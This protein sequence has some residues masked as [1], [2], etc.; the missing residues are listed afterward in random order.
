MERIFPWPPSTTDHQKCFVLLSHVV[1][2]WNGLSQQSSSSSREKGKTD[3]REG[4]DLFVSILIKDYHRGLTDSP[5]SKKNVQTNSRAVENKSL[6][7][8]ASL[9]NVSGGYR[10]HAMATTWLA[11]IESK[12]FV[13]MGL[14]GRK[15]YVGCRDDDDGPGWGRTNI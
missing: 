11:T 14:Y 1:D 8:L 15:W 10:G 13:L 7:T 12:R 9:S 3:R 5:K 6:T 2:N 4:S